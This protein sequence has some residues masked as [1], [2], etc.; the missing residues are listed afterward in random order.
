M[1]WLDVYWDDETVAHVAEH[2][3]TPDDYENALRN[4]IGEDVSDSSGRPMRFGF[5]LDGRKIAVLFEWIDRVTVLPI[6][7]F[8]VP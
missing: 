7:A 6:T 8:V 1:D 4:P 2:G 5:A 3:L